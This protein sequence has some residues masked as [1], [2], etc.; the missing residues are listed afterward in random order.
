M[1]VHDGRDIISTSYL[2][3]HAEGFQF[4]NRAPEEEMS[5]AFKS[6]LIIDFT[7][8]QAKECIQHIN[9]FFQKIINSITQF[10]ASKCLVL[11]AQENAHNNAITEAIPQFKF[12]ERH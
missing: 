7:Y 4:G 11:F 10:K 8:S 9:Y 6:A 5:N 1:T 2:Y 3:C 12:T